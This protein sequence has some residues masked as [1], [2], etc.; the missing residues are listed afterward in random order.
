A[1]VMLHPSGFEAAEHPWI[2]VRRVDVAYRGLPAHAAAMPFMGRNALDAAV[3]AYS[4]MAALR[5]HMLPTDRIHG[6]ITDGGQK[7]NIVPERAALSFYLRS[8]KPETLAV[9]AGRAEEIFNAAGAMAGVAV[10]IDWDPTPVY[11]PV[12]NN[13]PLALR[14]AT[15]IAETGRRSLPR[16]IIPD[17][18]TG[19]TDLGNV[20]VRVPAIH[21]TLAIAPP[22]V[23]IHSPEFTT[24]ARSKAADQGVV[25]GAIGLALT[26]VDY[27]GDDDVRAAVA[28]DFE[29]AGGP[30]DVEALLG[31]PP[32]RALPPADRV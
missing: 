13:H 27:L 22:G 26:A 6:I 17:A 30:L 9:L 18:L 21:P 15:N 14:W 24:H 23:T 3:A 12:R 16:G 2:G 25:D 19:S 4:G 1:A 5:Q 20:S 29:A 31:G 32:A 8:A 7:P 28:A 11:L 10:E